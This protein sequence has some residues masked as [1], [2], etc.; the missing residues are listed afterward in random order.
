MFLL[1]PDVAVVVIKYVNEFS[2]YKWN[3]SV[4]YYTIT[5]Q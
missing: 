5:Q 4:L 1:L 3:S 2:V